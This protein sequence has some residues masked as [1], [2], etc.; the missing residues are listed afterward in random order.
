MA[1]LS[2]DFS[3]VSI[4]GSA[5]VPKPLTA[6][7]EV[8]FEGH[9][10]FIASQYYYSHRSA[11]FRGEIHGDQPNACVHEV[12]CKYREEDTFELEHEAHLYQHNL[13][14]LQGVIV[15]R[16]YGLYK[17]SRFDEEEDKEWT[18]VCIIL[19]YFPADQSVPY[20]QRSLETQFVTFHPRRHITYQLL[21]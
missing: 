20:W 18:V 9:H 4:T 1:T 3:P 5:K 13:C 11:V 14:E 15:P 7:G 21:L 17:G 12:V 8:F 2:L 19:E 6:V 10:S 16:F